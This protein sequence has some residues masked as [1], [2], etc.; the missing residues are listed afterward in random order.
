VGE[1][2]R[3][4]ESADGCLPYFW[5]FFALLAAAGGG[6]VW[7]QHQSRTAPVID[8]QYVDVTPQVRQVE[9]QHT[10]VKRAEKA[11]VEPG[12][13]Q[14]YREQEPEKETFPVKFRPRRP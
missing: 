4:R 6:L 13:P 7:W 10:D 8:G 5:P 3:C 11:K 14:Y 2:S 12:T 9:H 1:P